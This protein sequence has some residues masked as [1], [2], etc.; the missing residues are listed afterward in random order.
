MQQLAD[1]GAKTVPVVA[2]DDEWVFAQSLGDVADLLELDYDVNPDLSP[3]ELIERMDVVLETAS[4]LV[5]QFP[6]SLLDETVRDR[7]RTYRTLF[8]HIFRIPEVFLDVTIIADDVVTYDGLKHPDPKRYATMDEIADYGDQVRKRIADWR[9]D[10]KS[11]DFTKMTEVYWGETPLHQVLERM[12]WHPA[13][14]TRQ[15]ALL[16]EDDFDI[17]PDRPLSAKELEGLPVPEKA[18]DD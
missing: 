4:R 9:E 7:D 16:L 3:D 6:N 14:H 11:I 13:Q 8:S 17:K 1:L 12:T 18:W 2:R 5:R 15:L 10:A